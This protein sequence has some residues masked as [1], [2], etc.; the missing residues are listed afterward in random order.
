[1][2]WIVVLDFPKLAQCFINM[3]ILVIIGCR[4]ANSCAYGL[5]DYKII[6]VRYDLFWGAPA[7]SLKSEWG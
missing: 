7:S 5:I 4:A 2:F 6:N 3:L 1:M